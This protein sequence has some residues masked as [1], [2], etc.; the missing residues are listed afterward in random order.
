M[1]QFRHPF[2]PDPGSSEKAEADKAAA[3]E[4]RK[5]VGITR[6]K[7]L[8]AKLALPKYHALYIA[9][10]RLFSERLKRD[11][12]ILAEL[13]TLPPDAKRSPLLKQISLAGK[14]SPT[15]SGAH[16]RHTNIA[17]AISL[18]LQHS[19][20]PS[21][22]PASLNGFLEPV[23]SAVIL[24]SFYQRWILTPLRAVS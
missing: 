14:W 6:H 2:R 21:Q 9:V 11:L 22:Y 1:E 4:K 12:D 24:C 15:P 8:V 20:T 19:Q 7:S 5:Q 23:E 13:D 18:L 17:T 10:A 16:D 3:K